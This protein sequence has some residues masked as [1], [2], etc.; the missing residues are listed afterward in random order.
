MLVTRLPS[1]RPSAWRTVAV[2]RPFELAD[3][4]ERG[5]VAN[6]RRAVDAISVLAWYCQDISAL[7]CAQADEE[8]AW[9]EALETPERSSASLFPGEAVLPTDWL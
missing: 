3:P 9:L 4:R 7:P 5:R 1:V 8:R 2:M 6:F